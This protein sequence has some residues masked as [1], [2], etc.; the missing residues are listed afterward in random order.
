MATDLYENKASSAISL[1][2][3][4]KKFGTV[5]A[6]NGVNLTVERGTVLALLGPN[7]AGKTTL[8][9]ILT[10]LLE[11]SSGVARV[12]GYDVSRE[13][14]KVR[15]I[16]G[17]T[18]QYA[19]IDENLT[20]LENLELVG[21]LYHLNKTEINQKAKDLLQKFD[22]IEAANRLAKTYSGGMR[23]RLDLAASLIGKPQILFLD[24][25]T[26]GLDPKA[27]REM[28]Q[29]IKNL[30][31][32]GITILLTTQYME[33]AEYL[34]DHIAIIN[35]GQIIEQGT[36]RELKAKLGYSTLDE[37]FLTLT[38]HERPF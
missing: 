36:S 31:Q 5:Q 35:H 2:N 24:E 1:E 15:Q 28:W 30:V 10:T 21:H 3:I 20:G 9:R 8:I 23:R 18:G 37:V 7:G 26:T 16:I 29:T 14:N 12:A 17:L 38:E 25:P 6:L 27:R 34:A 13:T 19:A 22:L 11:A 4:Y 33:E 32:E